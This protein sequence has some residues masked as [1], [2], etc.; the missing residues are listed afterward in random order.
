MTTES[1]YPLVGYRVVEFGMA[2]AAPAACHLLGDMGAEVVKIES[3]TRM[4]GLRQGRPMIGDDIV[5]GDQGQWPELQP[6]FH[7]VNRSKLS[8]AVNLKERRG[9]EL[10][11]ELVRVCDV[12]LDNFAPGV[13]DRLG[14]GYEDLK[15]F[16]PDIICV[17]M[18][19]A[20][21]WGP[22]R[23]ILGFA[24]VIAGLA[25]LGSLLGYYNG[26]FVGSI[27]V[28]FC[29]YLSAMHA[30]LVTL[31]A[32]R[33]RNLTGE[34]QSIEVVQW[35]ATTSLLAEA[36]LDYN[37]NKRVAKPQGNWQPNM[38][39]HDNYPCQGDD[40]W[41]SIAVKTDE[42]W[43]GLC[44]AL[45]KP[46]LA[47]DERFADS[48]C[49]LHHREELDEIVSA[50]TRERTSEEATQI[51]QREGVA[52]FPVMNIEDQFLD[53][54]FRARQIHVETEHPKIGI[55]ML[56]GLAWKLSRT[57]GGIQSHAPLLGQHTEYAFGELLGLPQEEV[58]KL[59]G[60]QVLY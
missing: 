30:T 54:H 52:A 6:T 8:V 59:Q 21:S 18:P 9:I 58:A 27:Q 39:P 42:E 17:S 55:E 36:I 15:K 5:G 28:A 25:G 3:R 19:A 26:P 56:Y 23:D 38:A 48:F 34:G 49:R 12:V 51:L 20:G 44:R 45:G 37:M 29:D 60:S 46:E 35:E 50:W 10:I 2:I 57:P 41:V 11:R 33:H 7:S 32:L 47:T 16:K 53:P 4:D 1:R 13:L 40:R 14:L 24:P 43:L 31:A 22:L